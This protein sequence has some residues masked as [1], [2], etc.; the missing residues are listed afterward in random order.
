MT[1]GKIASAIAFTP[2]TTAA[3][4]SVLAAEEDLIFSEYFS[5]AEG[6]EPPTGWTVEVAEG[7]PETDVWRFDNPGDRL[8]LEE[9]FDSPF[10]VY[11]SD[12]LSD[13]GMAESIILESP[14]FDA[15]DSEELFL[16]FNQYYEGIAT[17]ENASEIFVEASTNGTDWSTVYSS[18]TDE[19]L[20]GSPIVDLTDELAEEETAQI[21]FRFDG[22]WS[23]VW[24][25][26]DIEIFDFL[27]PG[28]AFTIRR[29]GSK[30]R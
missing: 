10:A 14:V 17:G 15:S 24:A 21:R 19:I 25:V 18:D 7:N 2:E 8:N 5:E 13:D 9:I 12:V 4:T 16:S 28:I 23:F 1:T 26:D 11:D 20:I 27:A 29:C 30:R 6:T 3:Y 22:N